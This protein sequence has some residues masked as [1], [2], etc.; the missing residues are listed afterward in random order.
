MTWPCSTTP[1]CTR[2]LP[3]MLR[4]Q[5]QRSSHCPAN[6][7]PWGSGV[8]SPGRPT[9]NSTL[10]PSSRARRRPQRGVIKRPGFSSHVLKRSSNRCPVDDATPLRQDGP[11]QHAR[12]QRPPCPQRLAY[13]PLTPTSMSRT[14]A[15]NSPRSSSPLR[16]MS[17]LARI[18]STCA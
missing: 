13:T 4:T 16:S 3:T 10:L 12:H 7:P 2:A 18:F 15:A 14:M 9:A 5:I 8:A 6:G 1:R 11:E 17:Y